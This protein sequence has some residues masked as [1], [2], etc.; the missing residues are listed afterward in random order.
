MNVYTKIRQTSVKMSNINKPRNNAR[1]NSNVEPLDF[2]PNYL[3]KSKYNTNYAFRW[4]FIAFIICSVIFGIMYLAINSD[5]LGMPGLSKFIQKSPI[6]PAFEPLRGKQNILIM[7]VDSNGKQAD[8]FDGTRT[9]SIMIVSIDKF[10]KSVN[11]ISIPRD[12]KVFLA[13][14]K[15]IDKINAAHAL[16]GKDL[17]IQTIERTFGIRIDHY[18]I[19]NFSGVKDFVASLDGI[20]V[21]VEKRMHYIDRAGGLYIDLYPG[22]QTLNPDQAEGYL[23][24]RHDA[25][26][27]LGRMGRQRWF[28]K[29]VVEKLKSPAVISKIPDII[30]S[31][32]KNIR[33]DMNA[34]ELTKLI[35][36]SK[37]IDMD[38]I[39]MATLPGKPSNHG[40]ISYWILDPDKTQN[41]IDR[42]I[43]REEPSVPSRT[44]TVS[45]SYSDEYASEIPRI[46]EILESQ[47]FEVKHSSLLQKN[48]HTQVVAHSEDAG[49]PPI[50]KLKNKIPE[51][52]SAA[53]VLDQSI[54]VGNTDYTIVL[55]D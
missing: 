54:Y 12:S 50:E 9:D 27:D 14:G 21:N 17:A 11:A 20:K 28:V 47:G 48:S 18:I 3:N 24:F 32:Q 30:Q 35:A 36:M 39:Q 33:T 38:N 41:I 2:S 40:Y 15:G 5:S 44:M 13:G 34:Y 43:Y 8:P 4:T 29:G 26:S 7:G 55:A 22:Y 25:V 31:A 42:L 10:G 6:A 1:N 23:R 16:G 19:V 51:L 52:K 46:K 45:L 49:Y 53:F 37:Q